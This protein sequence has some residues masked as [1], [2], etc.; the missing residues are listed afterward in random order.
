MSDATGI[1][2]VRR[3][4]RPLPVIVMADVSASMQ[5]DKI[6]ALNTGLGEMLTILR[7]FENPSV[8]LKMSIVTFGGSVQTVVPMMDPAQVSLPK[9]E[10]D[11][12]TP[13]G[14]AFNA[15]YNM[16]KDQSIVASNA[17]APTVALLT[18]GQPTD[19]WETPLRNLLT[20]SRTR[21]A[22]RFAMAIGD[23][24]DE[25]MLRQFLDNAEVPVFKSHEPEKIKSFL[26]QVSLYSVMKAKSNP[27][28]PPPPP[29]FQDDD[30]IVFDN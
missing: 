19:P 20:D 27:N 16:I 6:R 3:E 14:E 7:D 9:L 13:M 5:G 22:T 25:N 30:D 28:T 4:G 26:R 12:M 18:D 24:A 1:P 15:V 2:G 23:D 21:K 11:G 17:F 8:S 29:T 10:A